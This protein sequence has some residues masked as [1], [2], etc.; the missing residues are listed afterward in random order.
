MLNGATSITVTGTP[1]IAEIS[2]IV[3]NGADLG[4]ITYTLVN[5]VLDLGADQTVAAI[6]AIDTT[7]AAAIVAAAANDPALTLN[8]QYTLSDSAAHVDSADA[9]ILNG[10]TAITAT[11]TDGPDNVDLSNNA[12][13]PVTVGVTINLLAGND[14]FVGGSGNDII[15]GGA[16]ADNLTGG[17]GADTFT[18]VAGTDTTAAAVGAA[19]GVD[20]ITDFNS[21]DNDVLAVSALLKGAPE[22]FVNGNFLEVQLGKAA[23]N[24]IVITDELETNLFGGPADGSLNAVYVDLL[25]SAVS[26]SADSGILVFNNNGVVQVWYDASMGTNNAG[27]GAVLIGTITTT[28]ATADLANL[29]AAHFA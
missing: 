10:A 6:E 21:T 15:T 5:A 8:V 14:S 28:G 7:S 13:G 25:A 11:G 20:T 17:A 12:N 27:N 22:A 2:T 4:H 29:T 1:T 26:N 19:N 9:A 23:N 16:G 24:V 18:F 3:A